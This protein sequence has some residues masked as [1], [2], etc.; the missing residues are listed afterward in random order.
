MLSRPG[1]GYRP[2][3]AVGLREEFLIPLQAVVG[4]G[5][6]NGGEVVEGE[7]QLLADPH[8]H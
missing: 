8:F 2:F 7:G 5:G 4:A 1:N 6:A 3:L